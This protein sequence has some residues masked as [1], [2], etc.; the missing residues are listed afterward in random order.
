MRLPL[1]TI[2]IPTLNRAH[3]IGRAID[4]ALAQTY[5]NLEIIVSNNGSRDNTADLLRGYSDTR[6]RILQRSQTIPASEH[7]N[8]LIAES[9]GELFLGLSDDDYLEPGFVEAVVQ[10]FLEDPD[11]VMVYTRCWI[12][13]WD[14][15]VPSSLAPDIEA[16]PDFI[17][18]HYEQQR[19]VCWCACVLKIAE[20]RLVGPIPPGTIFG[21]MFY[22]TRI[23][24]RGK[25]GFVPEPLSHYVY[26][27]LATPS[28]SHATP[29]YDWGAETAAVAATALKAFIA[30]G[31]PRKRIK[32][33]AWRMKRYTAN[34]VANQFVWLAIRGASRWALLREAFRC[35]RVIGLRPGFWPHVALGIFAPRAFLTASVRRIASKRA[36]HGS[37]QTA[38]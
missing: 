34:S 18:E 8:Y 2:V 35:V 31:A 13:Y 36:S 37:V 19:E 20:L 38:K 6:L 17:A 24:Y 3:C 23:A 16:G 21:D 9:R 25:V 10:R 26:L 11:L 32:R 12:H 33:L 7:G 30:S 5:P 15:A 29:I 14:I 27:D 1:F 28:T 22:W 4:S